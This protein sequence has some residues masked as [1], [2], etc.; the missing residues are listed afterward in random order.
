MPKNTIA[1]VMTKYDYLLTAHPQAHEEEFASKNLKAMKSEIT[2]LTK[3]MSKSELSAQLEVIIDK[4]PTE[5]QR[6]AFRKLMETSTPEQLATFMASPKLLQA[7]LRGEGANFA[8]NW[9]ENAGLHIFTGVIVAAFLVLIITQIIRHAKYEFFSSQR[10]GECSDL[11][12]SVKDEINNTA[13]D[14]CL[15][16]ARHPETCER[17]SF[18]TYYDSG[19]DQWG[20]D[21][22]DP[23]CEATYKA[24]KKVEK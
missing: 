9:S 1:N 16:G 24:R 10:Y 18:K 11:T 19:V 22:S 2:A 4:V 17:D 13:K 21:Y 8:L 20:Y 12:Q 15:R 6:E 7:A 14:Y 3:S 5:K 23:K